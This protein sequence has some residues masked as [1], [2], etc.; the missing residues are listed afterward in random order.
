MTDKLIFMR[1][2]G[3]FRSITF[4]SITVS[5]NKFATVVRRV[6]VYYCANRQLSNTYF[7]HTLSALTTRRNIIRNILRHRTS[8]VLLYQ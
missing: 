3:Q 7:C 6:A 8:I 2:L 1:H 4:A 5:R